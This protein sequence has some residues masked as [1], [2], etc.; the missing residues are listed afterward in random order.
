MSAK[1][2][3]IFRKA[4]EQ[5]DGDEYFT[6]C[7]AAIRRFTRC[8]CVGREFSA[9]SD[10]EIYEADRKFAELMAPAAGVEGYWFGG[11][12]TN[13]DVRVLALLLAAEAL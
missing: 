10:C 8:T 7:C 11:R 2:R 13:R 3:S 9:V 5:L 12:S 4:A 6:G 1:F